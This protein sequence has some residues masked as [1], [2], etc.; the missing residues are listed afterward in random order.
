MFQLFEGLAGYIN[1][2]LSSFYNL[3]GDYGVS[4]IMLTVLVNIVTFP[5][6]RKQLESSKRM[7]E[8]QPELKKLQEKYKN[9]RAAYN[10]ASVEMMKKKN[11]N[12]LGGCL[13]L[14]VQ[15]PILISIFHLLRE[16]HLIVETV[17]NFSP[18][19]LFFNLD[20]T[21]PDPYFI[22]PVAA[23]GATFLQQRMVLTDPKQRFLMYIF[24]VMIL[25]ISFRFPAGLVLYW[26]TNSGVSAG[27]H[28]LFKKARE[29]RSSQAE[30]AAMDAEKKV[31]EKKEEK[32]EV[33]EKKKT[34]EKL[35]EK[36]SQPTGKKSGEEKKRKGSS[37]KKEQEVK[38]KAAK[39]APGAKKKSSKGK[40]KG[41]GK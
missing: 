11:V 30:T 39:R 17:E 36:S 10:K 29:K 13:P 34:V 38:G 9:D 20:L 15:L 18:Y 12:P 16:P 21:K 28:F 31:E 33:A 41:A 8:L 24:P 37:R 1:I 25:F 4:I 19:F 32:K 22:L 27:N 40:K 2:I 7:Q 3:T 6:T 35:P 23:A 26:L 14:L 5:L